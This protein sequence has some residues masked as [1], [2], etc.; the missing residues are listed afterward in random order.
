[1]RADVTAHGDRQQRHHRQR[2][3]LALGGVALGTALLAVGLA[4]PA[5]ALEPRTGED[6]TVEAGETVD[7]D[8][9]VAA[10]TLTV[11][12]T[13]AGDL[14]VAARE[15]VINGTVEGDL[16]GAAQSIVIA[17]AV[18][19]DVRVAA[20]ELIVEDGAEIGDDTIVFGY[21]LEAQEG[22]TIGGDVV[23][24]ARQ[25][26]LAGA[27]ADNLW[28]TAEGIEIGGEVGGNVDVRVGGGD[29]GFVVP[30]QGISVDAI[31]GGL[32]ITDTAVI[33]GDVRYESPAEADIAA[34]ARIGGQVIFDE[35]AEAA[36]EDDG[37]L[38][39]TLD[40]IGN[41]LRTFATLFVVG[42]LLVWL[43]PRAAGGASDTLRR[44]PWVSLGWG[45]L[46]FPLVAVA[47]G[48]L[49]FVTVVLAV[50]LG[51]VTLGGLAGFVIAA[52]L[53]V[54]F[55]LA[56][57]TGVAVGLLAPI[58]AAFLGGRLILRRP[59]PD[60]LGG[61]TLALLV[62]V[63]VYAVLQALPFVGWLVALAVTL[64]GLGAIIVWAWMSRRRRLPPTTAPA[65][66][67][68]SPTQP[69]PQ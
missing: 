58:V 67:A 33:E 36:R 64:F 47:F 41:V 2:R 17:G 69:Y 3:R 66:A 48:A 37:P 6:I 61:R 22:S 12:G 26:L 10:A 46:F 8:L 39:E 44:R 54:A 20:A 24:T 45:A 29:R 62:G 60:D 65:P 51:L 42:F 4:A 35:V 15:V 43:L 59:W 7:D 53:F 55:A 21:A 13:V 19:D 30:P 31:D 1:M 5:A 63:A 68:A 34:D 50:L 16:M 23:V 28:G 32:T 25:G 38:E 56:L 9:Y 18:E 49:L 40:R 14:I 11:E 57:A 27:V 52:G